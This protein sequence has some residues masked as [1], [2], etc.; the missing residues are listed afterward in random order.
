MPVNT[1]LVRRPPRRSPTTIATAV[2][3]PPAAGWAEGYTGGGANSPPVRTHLRRAIACPPSQLPPSRPRSTSRSAPSTSSP[4]SATPPCRARP[5]DESNAEDVRAAD[6]TRVEYAN[7][8]LLVKAPKLRSSISRKGG[9]VDVTI[10]LPAGSIWIPRG[11]LADVRCEGRSA[12]AGSGRGSVAS[13]SRT[14]RRWTSRAVLG[15]IAVER[16]SSHAEVTAG[17]ARRPPR[18][19]RIAV[20]ENSN[21]DTWVALAG[22]E[23]P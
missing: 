22:G 23:A 16:A 15:D 11:G 5:S 13:G 4:A 10:E 17:R 1:W 21:G 9:S 2:R 3:A 6:A 18:A 7:E 19:G 20:I 12:T 8:Q 14:P